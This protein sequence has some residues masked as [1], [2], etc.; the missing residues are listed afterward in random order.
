MNSKALNMLGMAR[1]ANRLS[2]GHDATA[3]SLNS[4]AAELVLTCADASDRL[5]G[6][7]EKACSEKG[8]TY[9]RT[10]YTMNETGAA[11]GAKLTAV[12]SVNDKG[13]AVRITEL[14]REDD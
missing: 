6:E 12:L 11:T 10:K 13:F 1:R 2:L 5:C 8:V 4:G 7:F 9:L 3:D 14:I